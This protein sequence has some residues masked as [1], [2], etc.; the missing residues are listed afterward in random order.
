MRKKY[1][2]TL[3]VMIVT[4]FIILGIAGVRHAQAASRTVTLEVE[5]MTCSMCKYTV[6]KSLKKVPGVTDAKVTFEPPEA[7]VTFDDEKA[8]VEDLTRA[9]TEAGYPSKPAE[10]K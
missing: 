5:N 3:A 8:A 7:I 10:N 6:K 1:P 2:E 9:T 4:L